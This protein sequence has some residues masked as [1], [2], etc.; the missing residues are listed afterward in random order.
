MV[1]GAHFSTQFA[2][3]LV[4]RFK[5]LIIIYTNFILNLIVKTIDIYFVL[6]FSKTLK[7]NYINKHKFSQTIILLPYIVPHR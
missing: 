4:T 1:L 7:A 5:T 6:F 3:S 2:R